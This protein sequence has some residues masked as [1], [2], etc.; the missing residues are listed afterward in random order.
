MRRDDPAHTRAAPPKRPSRLLQ[1]PSWLAALAGGVKQ[2][3]LTGPR[4]PSNA[5][6]VP[7]SL[8][9]GLALCAAALGPRA[10]TCWCP[11]AIACGAE[12]AGWIAP[13]G[14][15]TF[16]PPLSSVHASSLIQEDSHARGCWHLQSPGCRP[17]RLHLKADERVQSAGGA[18][19]ASC[20]ACKGADS[21]TPGT[22]GSGVDDR[23]GRSRGKRR[24]HPQGSC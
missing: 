2:H 23:R 4:A 19:F 9:A 3:P 8:P 11:Q 13:C 18:A 14:C 22:R 5:M 10:T 6:H 20:A 1:L 24:G 16:S 17:Q 12:P 15:C 7:I 21:L